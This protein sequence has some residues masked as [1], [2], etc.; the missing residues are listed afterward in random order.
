MSYEQKDNS[1][2]IFVNDRKEKDTHPDRSGTARIDGVDYWVSGW[3]KQDKNG[4]PY[5]SMSFKRKDNQL[6][7]LRD[8]LNARS[9]QAPA[10][11][12]SAADDLSDEVPF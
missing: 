11:R 3:L 4:K 12:Q 6:A 9:P 7:S 2:S 1:G 8:E 10:R 5:M